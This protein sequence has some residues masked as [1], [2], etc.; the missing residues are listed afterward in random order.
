MLPLE[1]VKDY[2]HGLLYTDQ[3]ELPLVQAL[4]M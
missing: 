2:L 1:A 4:G 3:V